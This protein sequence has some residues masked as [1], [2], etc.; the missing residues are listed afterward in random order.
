MSTHNRCTWNCGGTDCDAPTRPTLTTWRPHGMNQGD[1]VA[2][3]ESR[4]QQLR[5]L[6]T[7]PR[8]TVVGEVTGN[9]FPLQEQR[10][11]WAEWLRA[12][13]AAIFG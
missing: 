2:I 6:L 11:T 1:V 8:I 12:V 4:R 10:M 13:R 7:R 5:K 3:H 9:T